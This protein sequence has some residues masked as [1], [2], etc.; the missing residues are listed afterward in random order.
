MGMKCG[1]SPLSALKHLLAL[2]SGLLL[3]A[4]PVSAQSCTQADDALLWRVAGLEQAQHEV[5][6]FGSIHAGKPDFYPLPDRVEKAFRRADYLVLEADLSMQGEMETLLRIQRRA[7]LPPGEQ[8]AD[9]VSVQTMTELDAQLETLGVPSTLVMGMQ[10]WFVSVLLASLQVSMSGYLPQYGAESYLLAERGKGTTVLELEG[11]EQQLGFMESLNSESFLRY[12]LAGFDAE[13][14]ADIDALARAW[15]CADQEALETLIFDDLD[16]SGLSAAEVAQFNETFFLARNRDM[17]ER[18]AGFL[19]SGEGRYF[20]VVG[21]AHLLGEDSIL[22]LLRQ[23]GYRLQRV[24]A[25]E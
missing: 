16:D 4:N 21:A 13:S 12:T 5:H 22:S 23:R 6:L 25:Q 19:E 7:R 10:P 11:L 18:I 9:L 24:G 3:F 8:L 20:I 15:R 2:C 17:S 14:G 1:V